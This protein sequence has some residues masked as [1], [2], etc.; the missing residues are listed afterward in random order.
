MTIIK[1]VSLQIVSFVAE[2]VKQ[3]LDSQHCGCS[4]RESQNRAWARFAALLTFSHSETSL[5]IKGKLPNA[6]SRVWPALRF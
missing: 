6:S 3:T 4:C 1:K 2:V 5:T